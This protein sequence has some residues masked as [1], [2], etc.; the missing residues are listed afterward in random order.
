[1]T[2]TNLLLPEVE[3][4]SASY[5]YTI[6]TGDFNARSGLLSGTTEIDL[7][8]IDVQVDDVI[9]NSIS[10]ILANNDMSHH[11]C[12]CDT[13][14]NRAGSNLV[15]LCKSNDLVFLNGR[16]FSDKNVG[17]LNCKATSVIDYVIASYSS[18]ELFSNF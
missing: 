14:V 5:K 6:L 13:V 2:C 16:A 3:Q 9:V 1:M 18:L 15:G 8:N 17:K 4:L 7:H 11:R 12:S 10:S